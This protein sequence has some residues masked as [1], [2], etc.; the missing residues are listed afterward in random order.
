[1]TNI[2]VDTRIG[3]IEEIQPYMKYLLYTGENSEFAIEDQTPAKLHQ[4]VPPW[5]D[6]SMAKG[7]IR[8]QQV[9]VQGNPLYDVYTK[10]ECADDIKKEDVKV[11][12]FPA[13][14]ENEKHNKPFIIVAAGGTYMGVCSVI[15][16]FPTVAHFN[17]LGYHCFVLN[18]RV[19]GLG[20][21]PKPMEDLAA[22]YRFICNHRQ[23]FQLETLEYVV[24]GFSAGANLTS[25]WG[26][27]RQGYRKY[28]VVKPKALFPIYPVVSLE[29]EK[30]KPI[31]GNGQEDFLAIMLGEGYTEEVLD[32]YDI[33]KIFTTEYPPC[34]IVHCADDSDVPVENSRILKKLLDDAKIPAKI[35]IGVKGE[36]GFGDGGG[37]D[38][39]GWPERAIAFLE[40]L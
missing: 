34:Y 16:A 22:A 40:T 9:A 38:V 31:Q 13:E 12:H 5:N 7:L 11:F 37:S 1:M 27:E 6:E 10:D 28:G 2:T 36:H 24:C 8:L 3:D 32:S 29:I 39:E 20:V 17:K 4:A 19:G 21:F 15:E 18:Y 26:T 14:V 35:E 25:L 33:P 23:E 30:K